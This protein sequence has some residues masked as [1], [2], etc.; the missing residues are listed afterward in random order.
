MEISI[1]SLLPVLVLLLSLPQLS[2]ATTN[3][4][5][6]GCLKRYRHN[7]ASISQ[8]IYT[9]HNTSYNSVLQF[10]I[11]N[12][13]HA[14]LPASQKPLVIVTPLDESQVQTV[15][16]CAREYDLQIRTRSGGHDFE[17]LSY[18]TTSNVS[19]V[20]LDMIN[21]RSISVDLMTTT[22]WVQSGATLGELYY[23]ISRKSTTLGFPGGLW[24]SVGVGGLISGGGYGTLR[25]KYGLAA[26]N[27]EDVRMVDVNGRILDRTSMGE[28]L[29]WAIRGG[30]GSSFGVILSWK[31]KLVQVPPIVTIF[32]VDK[33]LEQNATALVHKWQSVAPDADEDLDIRIQANCVLSN[34]SSRKDKKTIRVTLVSLFL[35]RIDRLLP[36]MQQSFPELGL[37]REDCSELRWIQSALFFA[38][39]PIEASPSVL[40]NRTL[41]PKFPIKAKS[42]FVKEPIPEEGLDGIW[43]LLLLRDPE[44]TIVVLTPYGGRMS[45]ISE[46]EIPFPH[47]AGNLYMI[48]MGVLWAGDTQQALNWLRNLYNYLDPYVLNSP[49]SSYV[50][51]NDLDL[52]LNNL[53]GRTSYQQAS[54]WGK[55]YFRQN[56]D[57][58]VRVKFSVDPCNF[59]RHEQSIPPLPL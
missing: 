16:F 38:G 1:P 18:R 23:A 41:V 54:V 55:K 40:T 2:K 10:S 12:L 13:R 31:I 34:T 14:S 49:R 42:S 56:F 3:E 30:G 26:D 11:R 15:I 7:S 4:N 24:A 6:V 53:R 33:T 9:P 20:L 35:G 29:F 39:L 45:V 27:V 36:L 50:N 19:F 43:E 48:Y 47:R 46:S 51:Y 17:G 59:F 57:R 32:S 25:R 28:D 37:I 5:F 58:L 44:T 8:V 21:L 52:G 22:A